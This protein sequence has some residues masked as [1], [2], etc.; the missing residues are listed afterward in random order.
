VGALLG[1]VAGLPL[2][3]LGAAHPIPAAVAAGG[4]LA[5]WSG[6]LHIDGVADPVD[7]LAAPAGSEER[8]RTD[9]RAGTA[10]VV[11]IVVVL[12]LD[13]AAVAEIAGRGGGVLAEG[14]PGAA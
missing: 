4:L 1:L 2:L 6:A 13:V 10:G 12:G 11:A 8:A 5:A 9:P 7:A 14:G 3:A